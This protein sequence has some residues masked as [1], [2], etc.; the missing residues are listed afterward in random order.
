MVQAV[1][2]GGLIVFNDGL[3]IILLMA[4]NGIIMA[5]DVVIMLRCGMYISMFT[6]INYSYWSR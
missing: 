5:S 1:V 2:G 4:F 3:M 6:P